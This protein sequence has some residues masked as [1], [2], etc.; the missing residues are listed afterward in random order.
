MRELFGHLLMLVRGERRWRPRLDASRGEVIR[1]Q[2]LVAVK[3]APLLGLTP[4][5]VLRDAARRA[6]RRLVR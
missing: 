3:L 5:E 6:E 1:Q 2:Q 4:E